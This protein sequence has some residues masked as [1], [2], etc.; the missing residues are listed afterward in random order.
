MGVKNQ[1]SQDTEKTA[2][3]HEIG[4]IVSCTNKSNADSL[5]GDC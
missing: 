2:K 3:S 4:S 5:P 1:E